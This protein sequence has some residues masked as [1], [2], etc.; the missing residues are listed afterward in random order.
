MMI[1]I[2][3]ALRQTSKVLLTAAIL[4]SPLQLTHA[5]EQNTETK[6]SRFFEHIESSKEQHD[7][8][9]FHST[10]KGTK[11][12]CDVTAMSI[13]ARMH[14]QRVSPGTQSSLTSWVTRPTSGLG[15]GA[16]KNTASMYDS[17]HFRI[18]YINKTLFP[19]DEDAAL[20]MVVKNISASFEKAWET[21]HT[22]LGY[23][24]PPSDA[25]LISNG[26]NGLYDVYL[27]NLGPL[28][29]L[30]YTTSDHLGTSDPTRP[31][32]TYS[33]IMMDNDFSYAEYGYLDPTILLQVTAAHEYFH[34]V[35]FGYDPSEQVALAEQSS[36]WMEDKV[37]PNLHDNFNYIGEVYV[38]GNG[39]GQF[40]AMES[41]TDRN[42][43][44]QRNGGSQNTPEF[45]LDAFDPV[46]DIQYG[47]FLWARYLTERFGDQILLDIWNQAAL[48]AGDNSFA[49]T[50]NAL[51]AR[52]SSL[53]QAYQDYAVWAYRVENFLYGVNYPRVWVEKTFLSSIVNV[54]SST[55][56]SLQRTQALQ[57]HLSS[58]YIQVYQPAGDYLFVASGGQSGLSAVTE[59][60]AGVI[61]VQDVP[62]T[63]NQ[64][65]WVT[66]VN[67]VR[68]VFV[69]S[70][71][72]D[73]NDDMVWA[74]NSSQRGT[75]AVATLSTKNVTVVAA[76]AVPIAV[77]TVANT[78][79][80]TQQDIAAAKKS[81]GCL[82]PDKTSSWPVS[83]VVLL[84]MMGLVAFYRHFK[85]K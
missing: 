25:A 27:K 73:I 45:S 77:P 22:T 3:V 1:T 17:T 78:V 23:D 46:G 38:D 76:P 74:L 51:L 43:D 29:L 21:T 52:A 11:H 9:K 79:A 71:V 56:P 55:L 75:A 18:H 61:R 41:F 44:G 59:D 58:L 83:Y 63:A 34:A 32:G 67:C 48:V 85:F 60:S 16:Y 5:V 14:W 53:Q 84:L 12:R 50:Q 68:V 40:D 64:G 47:R 62:I 49:A 4:C 31:N 81:A 26:G 28:G 72:S 36:T 24:V 8:T 82:L 57:S 70:N 2:K 66:P 37:Y 39:N 54:S 35:Q 10:H 6:I 30:G 15:S 65:T 20:F 7:H 42:L 33:Y 80:A 69:I 13:K 19:N